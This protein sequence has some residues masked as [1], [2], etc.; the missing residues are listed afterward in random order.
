MF[1]LWLNQIARR[2]FAV[3][4]HRGWR[5]PYLILPSRP[6][7]EELETR[8]V[9]QCGPAGNPPPDL[10]FTTADIGTGSLRQVLTNVDQGMTN[11]VVF[12]IPTSDSGYDSSTGV[13]TISL[14]ARQPDRR[15]P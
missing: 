2:F 1:R 6:R 15:G 10:V 11:Q 3:R 4:R 9:P 13:Y 12:N 14:G 8:L 7:I 5:R